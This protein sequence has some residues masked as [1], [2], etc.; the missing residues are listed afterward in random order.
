MK[1]KLSLL[2]AFSLV[3]LLASCTNKDISP[4]EPSNSITTSPTTSPTEKPHAPALPPVR[5]ALPDFDV[6]SDEAKQAINDYLYEKGCDFS[7]EFVFLDT[8]NLDY[9]EGM[10]Q[11]N[12]DTANKKP[13]DIICAGIADPNNNSLKMFKNLELEPLTALYDDPQIKKLFP[14][15]LIDAF[16]ING[17]PY[18]LPKLLS[19]NDITY[20]FNPEKFSQSEV[21]SFSASPEDVAKLFKYNL[22]VTGNP[23]EL[24]PFYIANGVTYPKSGNAIVNGFEAFDDYFN[25]LF[26]ALNN[27]QL[28]YLPEGKQFDNPDVF[29]TQSVGRDSYI[30]NIPEGYMVKKF[31]SILYNVFSGVAI[32]K[33]SPNKERSLKFLQLALTDSKLANLIINGEDSVDYTLIDGYVCSENG[34]KLSRDIQFSFTGG[35][36]YNGVYPSASDFGIPNGITADEYYDKHVR[37]TPFSQFY[38]ETPRNLSD[39]LT[40]LATITEQFDKFVTS[41]TSTTSKDWLDSTV[42]KLNEL[43][44]NEIIAEV[45][46]QYDEFEGE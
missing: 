37:I 27:K 19:H 43:G 5:F 2:L 39:I 45:A 23:E 42:D 29:I 6:L 35:I 8:S 14:K 1:E 20:A 44:Y 18:L 13:I 12:E 17:I 15:I 30:P 31:P 32:P 38:F 41:G 7:L 22:A 26:S 33:T 36:F 9:W 21:D 16:S 4:T 24:L 46:K 25:E 28:V 3:F 40:R 34:E 10:Q 11:Y